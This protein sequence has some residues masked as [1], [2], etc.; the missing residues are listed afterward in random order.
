MN[1]LRDV[2]Q[3]YK[4]GKK[5]EPLDVAV[6][7]SPSRTKHLAHKIGFS[8]FSR[9]EK[10]IAEIESATQEKVATD[11]AE[12]L[13]HAQGLNKDVLLVLEAAAALVKGPKKYPVEGNPWREDRRDKDYAQKR[14]V[15]LNSGF[16]GS[17]RGIA[18]STGL[19]AIDID[20]IKW[21]TAQAL[22]VPVDSL[23]ISSYAD[24]NA[25]GQLTGG[26]RSTLQINDLEYNPDNPHPE[27][28]NRFKGS[29]SI[30]IDESGRIVKFGMA[31]AGQTGYTM[32]DPA[33]M[34]ID[35]SE[36]LQGVRQS[37]EQEVET[38]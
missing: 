33:H 14:D 36:F 31:R 26:V 1:T 13:A 11:F 37:V 22:T 18:V 4:T 29:M 9:E 30:D 2:H 6:E 15:M 35:L 7:K 25:D 32:E 5:G 16:E 21:Q 23:A 17:S 12:T 8:S 34:K 20:S 19:G 3:A 28:G 24:K 27:S 38:Q 10:V